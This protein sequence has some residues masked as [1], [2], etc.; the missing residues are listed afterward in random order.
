MASGRRNRVIRDSVH[1]ISEIDPQLRLVLDAKEVQR[2]RWIRQT[3]LAY[4]VFPGAEHSRFVHAL[5]TYTVARRVFHHLRALAVDFA[6]DYSPSEL[7]V[8]LEKAF[9]AAALCHDLGH[10]AFSHALEHVLLPEGLQTHEDCTLELLRLDHTD[11]AKQIANW[12]DLEEVIQ[13]LDRKHWVIGLCHLLAGDYD[14]DRWDYLLRDARATGVRYGVY[15]LAWMINTLLLKPNM[16]HQPLV[17]LDGPRGV[18]ALRQFLHA[19]R[20]MYHQV[21]YHATVR[22]AEQLLRA[23]FERALDTRRP[24]FGEADERSLVPESL[25]RPIFERRKPTIEQFL[26]TDDLLVLFTI[27]NW[28]ESTRDPVLKYLCRCLVGRHLPKEVPLPAEIRSG[29]AKLPDELLIQVREGVRKALTGKIPSEFLEDALD[30]LVLVDHCSFK[31]PTLNEVFFDVDGVTKQAHEIQALGPEFR[32]DDLISR[33]TLVR[34][35]VPSDA[36]DV[37]QTVRTEMN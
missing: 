9:L 24:G 20:Y 30:Y 3:A 7:T 6:I 12:C 2:L 15:D 19:R 35:Y 37:A 28:A 31:P 33:F 10:T 23:I 8:D 29:E 17:V 16:Q 13:I 1:G 34:L 11:V 26:G 21:Y 32:F 14:V 25:R 22:G 4:L 18:V 36:R 5:G 27:R